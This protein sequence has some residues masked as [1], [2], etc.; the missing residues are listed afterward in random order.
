MKY[1]KLVRDKILE[2]YA[3][4]GNKHRWHIA[5][6]DEEYWQKL[7][8]KLREEVEEFIADENTEELADVEEVIEAIYAFKHYSRVE[9]QQVRD[10]KKQER[11]GFTRRLILDEV[12]K[13]KGG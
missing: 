13:K 9:V 10:K 1:H 5:G 8:E 11:G 2:Y 7:K 4:T 3:Y 12:L 6:S